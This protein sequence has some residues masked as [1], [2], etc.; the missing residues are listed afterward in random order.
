MTCDF[1]FLL[2]KRTIIVVWILAGLGTIVMQYVL[3][4]KMEI[5]NYIIFISSFSH[6]TDLKNLYDAYPSEYFDLYLYGPV[7]AIFIAPFAL[8]P[9][10]ISYPL[11][12]LLNALILLY[13]IFQL[14]VNDKKR[15]IVSWIV[16]GC[17]ITSMLNSQFHAMSVA[18]IILCYTLIPK[19]QYF[20]AAFFLVLG[21]FIKLY[22]IIG[23]A[24]FFFVDDKPRYVLW[25]A[26]WAII[27]FILPMAFVGMGYTI[28]C[29][30]DWF[31]VLVQ[32]NSENVMLEN[33]RTDVCVMGMF[34]RLLHNETLSNLYFIVPGLLIFA[35]P[36]WKI[37]KFKNVVIQLR[38]L[39]SALLFVILASTGTESPTIII[40]FVGVAI[41]F[42]ISE[43]TKLDI[44][45]LV[46]ALIISS[47]SPTDIFPE[48]IRD[49][50]I[51]QYAL[52]VLPLLVVWLKLNWEMA[53]EFFLSTD[54]ANQSDM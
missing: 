25:L 15:A 5:N 35:M 6:L 23:L 36:F 53:R 8:L 2:K 21:V 3:G 12:N 39:A 29:Y 49:N 1:Q 48:Y 46:F 41:W 32:K 27:L 10:F 52:M 38:V 19:K 43:K 51:N 33:S 44:S 40:G 22:G 17:L 50:Y 31:N 13:A 42:V 24:F 37:S 18:F 28:Q 20:W 54:G 26:F 16:L 7:F 47:F 4:T 14:P 45:L 9:T 30:T 34:R 11:W